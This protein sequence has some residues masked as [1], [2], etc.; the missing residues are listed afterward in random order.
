MRKRNIDYFGNASIWWLLTMLPLLII[1]LYTIHNGGDVH[2]YVQS[3][4]GMMEGIPLYD[5]IDQLIGVNGY[6]PLTTANTLW[7]VD[8]ITWMVDIAFL[9][10]CVSVVVFIPLWFSSFAE[11]ALEKARR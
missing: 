3:M 11:K 4:V 5:T 7:L 6:L 8:F 9:R 2:S 10:L 1:G